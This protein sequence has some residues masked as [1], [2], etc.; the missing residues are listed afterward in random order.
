MTARVVAAM[1]GGVDSSVAAALLVEAGYEV[2][3]VSMQLR[4]RAAAE[5]SPSQKCL[6]DDIADARRVA[7]KI[8]IPHYVLNLEAEFR[9]SVVADF[10][11]EYGR[12][13]TPNPC[14]RCNQRIKFG[15]LMDKARE[16]GADFV[17]TGHY[18]RTDKAA[19]GRFRLLCGADG[20]KDQ[21]YF[22]FALT[23]TQLARTLFPV[24]AMTKPEVRA[25][26]ARRG[27]PVAEKR[28]S[29]E[30]CFVPDN[31][32]AGFL[33]REGRKAPPGNIGDRAGRVLGRHDGIHRFTVGQRKR[34]GLS[35]PTPLFVLAVDAASATVTVG[36][37]DELY[38]DRLTAAEVNWIAPEPAAP[39]DTAC[40]IR[41]R[42]QA[43]PC[44]VFPRPGGRVEVR[45]PAGERAV[46]PGQAVVFYDGDAVLGGGWIESAG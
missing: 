42:Q 31:D 5:A 11:A 37:E 40:K 44:R 32:Y 17:A 15:L 6:Q 2:I 26:A 38:R 13:R 22:L 8:G 1:S 30:I 16:L 9:R 45:F 34:L 28:E 36:E 21:S 23:Q 7:A 27:L 19:D 35:H 4:S 20:G 39:F 10:L 46:T 41:Y 43:V 12:G 33:E 3:G 29:Q 18:A 25:Q 14:V 24:G